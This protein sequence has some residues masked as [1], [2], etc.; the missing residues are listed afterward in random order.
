MDVH[1]HLLLNHLPIVGTFL[2]L[3]LLLLAALGRQRGALTA[4]VLVLGLAG[5]GAGAAYLTGEPAEEVVE[6]LAGTSEAA[7]E[8]HEDRARLATALALLTALVGGVGLVRPN[9]GPLIPT[10]FVLTSLS[11]TAMAWTGAA[12]G[13]IRHNALR[14]DLQGATADGGQDTKEDRSDHDD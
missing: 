5:G 3:P 1:L 8:A 4:A 12:G 11:A 2:A 13:Q 7:L 9:A 6:D 14:G 10:L